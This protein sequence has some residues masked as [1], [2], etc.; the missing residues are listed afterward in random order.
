MQ[1]T[2]VFVYNANSG[3][4]S[5]LAD[6]THKI[7]SPQTYKCNLCA[8]TCSPFRIRKKLKEFLYCLNM[9]AEFLHKDEFKE[10]YSIEDISFPAIFIKQESDLELLIDSDLINSCKNIFNLKEVIKDK[11]SLYKFKYYNQPLHSTNL[12]VGRTST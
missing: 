7:I 9:P 10:R 3:L 8:I 5:T 6:T 2:L 1:T 12:Y 4:F 11:I